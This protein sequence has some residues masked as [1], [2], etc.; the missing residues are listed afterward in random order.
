MSEKVLLP[1]WRRVVPF[2]HADGANLWYHQRGSGSP[3]LFISGLGGDHTI[4]NREAALLAD[5]YSVV[6]FDNRGT[7]ESSLEPGWMVDERYTMTRLAHDVVAIIDT[8]DLP[9]V[10]LVGSSM[11]GI[12]AQVVARDYPSR[13]Q[14]LSLHSTWCEGRELARLRMES[15]LTLLDKIE[16]SEFL[17]HLAPWIWSNETLVTR[18]D[19][20]DKFR[21]IQR[22]RGATISKRVYELQGKAVEEVHSTE[23]SGFEKPT[24]VTAGSDDILVPASESRKISEAIPGSHFELFPGCGHASIVEA[25]DLFHEVQ[26]DFIR[27]RDGGIVEEEQYEE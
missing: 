8:L 1:K 5:E 9:P 13:L 6:L 23:I 26:L 3:V 22:A 16:L 21:E 10:H 25:E 2:I 11:G 24:L 20:I 15:W 12:V 14:S 27:S 19:R 4:W 7:G 18:R 17:L